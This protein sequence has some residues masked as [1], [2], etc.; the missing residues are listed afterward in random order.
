M[1]PR[2]AGSGAGPILG[3]VRSVA[4]GLAMAAFLSGTISSSDEANAIRFDEV[5]AE[6]GLDFVHDTGATGEF[7]LPEIMGSGVALL[8]YDGDGDLD[9]YLL[10]GARLA[11]GGGPPGSVAGPSTNRLY[12]NDL[13]GGRIR[14]QEVTTAAGVGDPGYAMGSAT[15]DYDNDGDLD[16]YITNFGSNRLYRNNGDGTFS[17]VT[18]AAGVDDPRWST[19][20]CFCDLD[21]DGFL[22][23]FVATYV[24]FTVAGNRLC[25]DTVGAQDYC[26]PSVYNPQPDRLFRNLGNGRFQD[27][28]SPSGI[29]S[30]RGAG[31]GVACADFNGDGWMDL[32]VANDGTPNHLWINRRD[33]TFL[34]MGLSSGTAYNAQGRAEAGMGIAAGDFDEDGDEDLFVTNLRQ[35]TNTLYVN[36][37]TGN[38]YDAT[39]ESNLALDSLPFTGFGT[40]W[41]DYDGDGRLDLFVANGAVEILESL[42]HTSY[43]YPQKNLLFRQVRRGYFLEVSRSCGSPFGLLEVSRGAAFGDIDNDGDLDILLSNNRGPVRLLVNRSAPARHWLLVR[44]EG[45][46]SNR[47]GLGS[48][49]ILKL[50]GGARLHRRVHTDGSYLSASDLR[51][52]FGLGEITEVESLEVHWPS[53]RK[54]SWKGLPADQ[55]LVLREG[56]GESL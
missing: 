56:S 33:G 30:A 28:T 8:D 43:P 24:D 39:I 2:Q 47:R 6:T 34:E 1:T 17:D 19:S 4:M 44:L 11:A 32:Y 23:L 36:D 38:F 25:H 12:R 18:A 41:A 13:S 51:V 22:D 37:G 49:L 10:Q 21:N 26:S 16:L 54:E 31:L 52:H 20:A 7:Y 53:G 27:V 45:T 40:D 55:I 48:R 15:G 29:G 14:F 46:R 9:V 5:A 35:E 3:P 50:P 42:R